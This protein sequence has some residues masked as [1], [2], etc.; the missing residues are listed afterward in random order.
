M[1]CN[2][3]LRISWATLQYSYAL[4]WG[5]GFT[6]DHFCSVNISEIHQ[7][8]SLRLCYG[9]VRWSPPRPENTASLLSQ[10]AAP[11]RRDCSSYGSPKFASSLLSRLAYLW[12]HTIQQWYSRYWPL[13]KQLVTLCFACRNDKWGRF[14]Q[15][16]PALM[17]VKG[18][19]ADYFLF[20]KCT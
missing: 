5:M 19:P 8:N 12:V 13:T 1:F 4:H 14:F 15:F 11:V 2:T 16:H 7:K 20:K 6:G 17:W 9:C 3:R 10:A 18:V